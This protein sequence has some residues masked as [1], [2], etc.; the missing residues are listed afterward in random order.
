M[1]IKL[2]IAK[3]ITQKYCH[4]KCLYLKKITKNDIFL[5]NWKIEICL[6]LTLKV[7]ENIFYKNKVSKAIILSLTA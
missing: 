5:K 3:L 2:K 6:S 1:R 7:V 4:I